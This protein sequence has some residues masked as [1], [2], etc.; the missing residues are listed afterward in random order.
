MIIDKRYQTRKHILYIYIYIFIIKA[1]QT[2]NLTR[3]GYKELIS[4]SVIFPCLHAF[5][6]NKD[7][8]HNIMRLIIINICS[9]ILNSLFNNQRFHLKLLYHCFLSHIKSFIFQFLTEFQY[10]INFN[11][12]FL[13]FYSPIYIW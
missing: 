10:F 11:C 6:Q 2:K 8:F 12:T 3:S 13:F 7:N 1:H 9:S 4:T 5:I